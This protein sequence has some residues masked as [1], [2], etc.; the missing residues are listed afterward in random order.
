VKI[1]VIDGLGGG[2]GC[3]IIEN[4]KR[5]LKNSIEITALGINSQAT[6]N[7][8]KAGAYRGATGENAI[9]VT[10]RDMDILVGPLGI[11]IAG[12]MMGEVTTGIT[13]IVMS[14]PAKKFLLCV[15]QPHVELIEVNDQPV[16]VLIKKLVARVREFIQSN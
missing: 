14:S 11:I 7:M 8:I 12:A 16:A 4:L 3:Q 2:L 1:A 15:K 10:A 13:E 9:R 5:D 6:F